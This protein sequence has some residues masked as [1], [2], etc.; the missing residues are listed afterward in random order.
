LQNLVQH[1]VT[2]KEVA[3]EDGVTATRKGV[4]ATREGALSMDKSIL[5]TGHPMVFIESP[6]V[7]PIE[8]NEVC[9]QISASSYA[10]LHTS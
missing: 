8:I 3:T 5:A 10:G 7:S 6:R 1:V 4:L 2:T 9:G